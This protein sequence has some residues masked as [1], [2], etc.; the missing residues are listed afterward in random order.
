[1]TAPERQE[2]IAATLRRERRA[3]VANLASALDCSERTIRY[4]IEALSVSGFPVVTIQGRHGGG[5]ELMEGYHPQSPTLSPEQILALREIIKDTTDPL[6]RMTLGSILDQ[7]SP[8][9]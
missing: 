9:R 3:T 8:T 5:V 7:F 1:M 2:L 4:D 6:K